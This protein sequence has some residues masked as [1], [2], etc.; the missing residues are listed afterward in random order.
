MASRLT[1]ANYQSRKIK[2]RDAIEAAKRA[3]GD[4]A[5]HHELGEATEDDVARASAAVK[6]LED[7]LVGLDAAWARTLEVQ[8]AALEQASRDAANEAHAT[9]SK[10]IEARF[11]SA[12]AIQKLAGQ[13]ADAYAEHERDGRTII[14]TAQQHKR[15]FDGAKLQHL[16]EL[17]EGSFN[18][19]RK[20]LARTLGMRGLDMTGL[21]F[22]GYATDP[23][24]QRDLAVFA[25]WEARR[26]AGYVAE[27]QQT[28]LAEA[29]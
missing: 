2:L 3:H 11:Q 20:P 21:P 18:D 12:L 25:D 29:A 9:I 16:R 27:L 19:I 23:E 22:A 15:H 8:G 13:L 28:E 6:E 4:A 10:L 14:L 26:V 7:R 17:I 5:M 24:T 1:E